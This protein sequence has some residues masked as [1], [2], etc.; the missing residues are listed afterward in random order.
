MISKAL[1]DTLFRKAITQNQYVNIQHVLNKNSQYF[2]EVLEDYI[3]I[4]KY[5]DLENY[6][7]ID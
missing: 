1:Y 2:N 6:I 7:I 4:D 5:E 3:V